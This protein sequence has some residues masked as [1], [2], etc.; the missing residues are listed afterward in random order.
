VRSCGR[1]VRA[2]ERGMRSTALIHND[3]NGL[4]ERVEIDFLSDKPDECLRKFRF[5]VD[6]VSEHFYGSAVLLTKPVE[7]PMIVVLLHHLV[8]GVRKSHPVDIE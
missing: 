7:M 1:G 6:V 3:I 8:R 5:F 4:F 2:T